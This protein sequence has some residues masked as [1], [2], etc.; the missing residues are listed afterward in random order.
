MA[1]KQNMDEPDG[2]QQILAGTVRQRIY[3][4]RQD[5]WWDT[6]ASKIILDALEDH[7]AMPPNNR[8]RCMLVLAE[9]NMGKSALAA[10]F[11]RRHPKW[12]DEESGTLHRPVILVELKL[13]LTAEYFLIEL[14]KAAGL[15]SEEKTYT[16]LFRCVTSQIAPLN[17]SLILVDEAQRLLKARQDA[18]QAILELIKTLSTILKRP[19]VALATPSADVLWAKDDQLSRRF[20]RYEL[21]PWKLDGEL[22]CLVK[23]IL[24]NMPMR[25]GYDDSIYQQEAILN[26]IVALR[27]DTGGILAIIQD[28]AATV[29]KQGREFISQADILAE[30]TKPR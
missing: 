24:D 11:C 17:P 10:E 30:L 7:L 25:E 8:P 13:P 19:V 28:T 5:T 18:R 4:L 1:R 21:P 29:L 6:E 14:L 16:Q 15:P 2:W 26:E 27:R 20:I 22:Q 9:S 3:Y 12:R 23:T